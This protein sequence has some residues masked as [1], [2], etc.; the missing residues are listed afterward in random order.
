MKNKT[1]KLIIIVSSCLFILF[2]CL[3]FAKRIPVRAVSKIKDINTKDVKVYSETIDIEEFEGQFKI[4]FV[5]DAHV[6]LC[7]GR[8]SELKEK[9]KERNE[10][11]SRNSKS[12]SKNFSITMDYIKSEN[13]DLVIF[14]G[15][16][17]DEATE[18]A[19]DFL[20]KEFEQMDCPYIYLMGNHDFEY[21]DEYFSEKAYEEYLPRLSKINGDA[22]GIEA[23]RYEDFTILALDDSNNQVP[24]GTAEIINQLKSEGK[25]VI[26]ALHV[27]IEPKDGAELIA[28]TNEVWP[29]DNPAYSRVLMGEHAKTPNEETA[30]LIDFVSDDDGLVCKVI[31][32]HT[33][34]YSVDEIN[35]HATQ[36]I[37]PAGYER[38]IVE[39]II[40]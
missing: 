1:K 36:T 30:A 33:H 23:V 27:P 4:I 14:G 19:I 31:A 6:A 9:T 11:F 37:A 8:D 35:S 15:D 13:P 10:G 28:K 5:S 21:K 39:I 22:D 12:S 26:V 20:E 2:L 16:I 34:F 7:D 18:A 24:N 32:G 3:L 25:P 17:A 38:G 40:K 29:S